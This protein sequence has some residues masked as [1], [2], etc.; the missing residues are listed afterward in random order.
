MTHN[1]PRLKADGT[2]LRFTT[3]EL[4]VQRAAAEFLREISPLERLHRPDSSDLS[5]ATRREIGGLGWFSLSL[6]EAHGGSGLTAVEHALFFREAGHHCGAIDL[7]TQSLAVL[8]AGQ[9]DGLQTSFASGAEAV[10]LAVPEGSSF[11][12]LGAPSAR[13]AICVEREGAAIYPVPAAMTRRPAL[14]PATTMSV[15]PALPRSALAKSAGP[16]VWKMGQLGAT[17]ML[18]G[19]AERAISLIVDYAKVRETFGRKIG[20]YQAVRHPCADMEVRAEAARCQL[21][22][23]AASLKEQRDDAESQLDAAKHIANEA[24]LTN[25]DV[26]IQLHG[27]VGVTDEYHAHLLLKRALLL[28]RLFGCKRTLLARLLHATLQD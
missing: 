14:D 27:G 25:A 28:G 17:A 7:L 22:Y 1:A 18:V 26:N 8:A 9:D 2:F 10:M 3:D 20:S 6:P 13:Y 12:M 21:W 23:A 19:V 15:V 16:S 24:A 5:A 11:R 4:A